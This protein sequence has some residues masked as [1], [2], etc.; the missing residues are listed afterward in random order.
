M[1]AAGFYGQAGLQWSMAQ[2]YAERA[3]DMQGSAAGVAEYE[4]NVD[5]ARK[6]SGLTRA[7][8]GIGSVV[9]VSGIGVTVA[10]G[11]R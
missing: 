9:L 3:R 10:L 1:V 8:I 5:Y 7:S 4:F 11:K 2:G 6:K